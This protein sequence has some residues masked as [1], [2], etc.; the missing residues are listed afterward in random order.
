MKKG[1]GAIIDGR[2]IVSKTTIERSY[3]GLDGE[4]GVGMPVGPGEA[5]VH[6]GYYGFFH[7]GTR[8]IQGPK[9]RAEYRWYDFRGWSGVYASIG[10]EWTYDQV[11]RSEGAIVGA[12]RIPL[13]VR[14]SRKRRSSLCYRFTDPVRRQ[15]VIWVERTRDDRF[16]GNIFFV[17]NLTNGTGVQTNPMNLPTAIAQSGPSDVI[18]LLQNTGNIPVP[19]ATFLLQ[20]LQQVAGFGS[21]AS[22]QISLAGG[23]I[24]TVN[25]LTG[26]GR[27]ILEGGTNGITLA[28][29]NRVFGIQT[30]GNTNAGIFG[31]G[32]SGGSISDVI[33]VLAGGSDGVQLLNTGGAF[34]VA[35]S[36]FQGT[37]GR[38][39]DVTGHS[40]SVAVTGNTM[41]SFSGLNGVRFTNME[42]S[43]LVQGNTISLNFIP[44]EVVQ[45]GQPN[46]LTGTITGNTMAFLGAIGS[47][48]LTSGPTQFDISNNTVNTVNSG[49]QPGI[50][51]V[52][53]GASNHGFR[54]ND[55][56]FTNINLGGQWAV[57]VTGASTGMIE[58][59]VR[60]NTFT[61]LNGIDVVFN[62]TS[63]TYSAII[64][65]NADTG[66]TGAIIH[67]LVPVTVSSSI[68]GRLNGNTGNRGSTLEILLFAAS[69][70]ALQV[71]DLPNLSANNG[72]MSVLNVGGVNVPPA[73]CPCLS[74]QP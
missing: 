38:A 63:G 19:G 25:D 9:V 10:G 28:N 49:G 47:F 14:R 22:A 7:H 21:S 55:N 31:S 40:G 72:G 53:G 64:E 59:Q 8:S 62:P 3:G 32:V 67:A 36:N 11:H 43:F 18:F 4:A 26:A 58:G 37:G 30:Q 39:V 41:V 52:Y 51:F 1:T 42:G 35:G 27:G 33:F 24:L 17:D 60:G 71:E 73:T 23:S 12:I 66:G 20:D 54:V 2:Q 16:L 61:T 6:A 70:S 44:F 50:A 74:C 46:A 48:Q 65:N 13:R 15:R 68:C 5:W 34:S 29:G 57:S 69:G 56:T 45:T